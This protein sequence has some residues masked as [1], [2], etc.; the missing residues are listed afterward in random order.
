VAKGGAGVGEE[1]HAETEGGRMSQAEQISE[2]VVEDTPRRKRGRPVVHSEQLLNLAHR[3]SGAST[4]R[5]RQNFLYMTRAIRVL[6]YEPDFYWLVGTREEIS[7]GKKILRNTILVE[8]GRIE[9]ED[10]L[11]VIARQ[12][13]E[14]KPRCKDALVMIRRWRTGKTLAGDV[15][16]LTKA[17]IQTVEDYCA[18]RADT[19]LQ[20]VL[21]AL[22]NAADAFQEQ[23]SWDPLTFL[24]VSSPSS[25][26]AAPLP[27]P[28]SNRAGS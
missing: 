15:L 17:V 9:D 22:A 16:S 4:V 7:A 14:I 11:R 23:D 18:A 24:T 5:G 27:S 2:N 28:S 12:V 26:T 10:D 13:C 20:I 19:T 1:E 21:A 25:S 3:Y 6:D 8:L